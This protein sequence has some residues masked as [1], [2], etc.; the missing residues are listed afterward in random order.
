MPPS[1]EQG[2]IRRDLRA[3]RRSLD[4]EAQTNAALNV[5]DLV[6]QIPEIQT[7]KTL[8]FY[9]PIDGELS[10]IPLMKIHL[11]EGRRCTLP[12]IPDA[13]SSRLGF[14]LFTPTTRFHNDRF[15]IPSPSPNSSAVIEAEDHQVI[16]TPCVGFTRQGARLGFGGGFYDRLFAQLPRSVLRLGLAHHCQALPTDWKSNAWDQ[17]LDI[18]VTDREVIR[19]HAMT[20]EQAG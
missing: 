12:W 20:P 3:R 18:I 19:P 16:I 17:P 5:R 9:W 2:A 8:A 7:A 6:H 14:Q 15:G 13:P 10:P 11:K 4:V 1:P